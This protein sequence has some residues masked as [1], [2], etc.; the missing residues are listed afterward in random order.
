LKRGREEA[1]VT[2]DARDAPAVAEVE[3]HDRLTRDK[4]HSKEW[5]WLGIAVLG[6]A[7]LGALILGVSAYAADDDSGALFSRSDFAVLAAVVGFVLGAIAGFVLWAV[8]VLLR[9]AVASRGSGP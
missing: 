5:H 6:G 1:R 2:R 7:L 8:W 4:N 9:T 3:R